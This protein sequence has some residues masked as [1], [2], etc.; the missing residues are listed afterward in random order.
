MPEPLIPP[1]SQFCDSN[2]HPFAGGTITTYIPGTDTPKDTWE[3]LAGTVLNTNPIVLDAAGR[4]LIYGVGDYRFVL[5]DAQGNLIYD[6]LT[7]A[8]DTS[9]FVSTADMTAAIQVETNRAMAAEN[10]ETARAEAAENTLTTNLNAEIARAEAAEA[11][12]QSQITSLGSGGT[13]LPITQFGGGVT[14]S[15]GTAS[16][17]FSHAFGATP[18]VTATV[19]QSGVNAI[20]IAISATSTT[21]FSVIASTYGAGPS[22]APATTGF[23]W[24]AVGAP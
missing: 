8:I 6:Q 13:G 18:V 11:N 14:N 5:R 3:D 10:A 9:A 22:A 21:S 15:S 2:G 24:I 23:Y 20:W 16:V 12:L 7:S 1:E 17:T 4:A 19:A